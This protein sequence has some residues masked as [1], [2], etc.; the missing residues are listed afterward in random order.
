[1][2][3]AGRRTRVWPM[4]ELLVRRVGWLRLFPLMAGLLVQWVA[5]AV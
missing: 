5:S 2:R 3:L 4:A 1:M